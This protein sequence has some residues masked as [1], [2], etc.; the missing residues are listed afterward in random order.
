MDQQARIRA[1]RSHITQ[2]HNSRFS[3]YTR[4]PNPKPTFRFTSP[5]MDWEKGDGETN[6][7]GTFSETT[8]RMTRR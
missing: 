8:S 3:D 1:A 6:G 2:V 4:N 5:E 7:A